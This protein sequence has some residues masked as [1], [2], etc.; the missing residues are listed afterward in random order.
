MTVTQRKRHVK[1][2]TWSS[3]L[4]NLCHARSPSS[5]WAR[6]YR[7][8]TKQAFPDTELF[9]LLLRPSSPRFSPHSQSSSPPSRTLP[10]PPR[11]V[12]LRQPLTRF[13]STRERA[14]SRASTNLSETPFSSG[15]T[16]PR[17]PQR[18]LLDSST[19][20]GLPR[21]GHG[22]KRW[23]ARCGRRTCWASS[24]LGCSARK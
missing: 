13:H 1:R 12:H 6:A 22:R 9:S 3:R 23:A 20:G 16:R 7:N 10:K 2:S 5:R 24:L 17:P 21:K 15:H 8:L 11:G 19:L 14:F 4:R 18:L